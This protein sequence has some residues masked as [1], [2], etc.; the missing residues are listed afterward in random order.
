MYFQARHENFDRFVK[1]VEPNIP[2]IFETQIRC[3]SKPTYKYCKSRVMVT[4]FYKPLSK[5]N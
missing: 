4:M 2:D 5:R 1:N 3:F